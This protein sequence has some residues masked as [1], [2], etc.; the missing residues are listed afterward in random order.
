MG[1]DS[2]LRVPL[3]LTG[4]EVGVLSLTWTTRLSCLH[5]WQGP[6]LYPLA[7]PLTL[8]PHLPPQLCHLEHPLLPL[9]QFRPVVPLL[10]PSLSAL[11]PPVP[12]L[13]PFPLAL[14]PPVHHG[15][16]AHSL[17]FHPSHVPFVVAMCRT[18]FVIPRLHHL[19]TFLPSMWTTSR[20]HTRHI[21]MTSP[22]R[23]PSL[24]PPRPPPTLSSHLCP[25][26][27]LPPRP[28]LHLHQPSHR[29][30]MPLPL[31]R[32]LAV[33]LLDPPLPPMRARIG[34]PH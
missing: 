34:S 6:T 27:H 15:P 21:P 4:S 30:P 19:Q 14:S 10:V 5:G 24:P 13:V 31:S 9:R 16:L 22:H 7:P 12:L 2:L 20:R 18:S 17:H 25:L 23:P 29:P 1:P 32:L 28:L 26:L 3:F 11:S 33:P 8:P